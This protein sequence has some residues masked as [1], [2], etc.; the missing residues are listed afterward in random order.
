[1]D[2]AV[3]SDT[4]SST[5]GS[6]TDSPIAGTKRH[7]LEGIQELP[8]NVSDNG[9][10]ADAGASVSATLEASHSAFMPVGAKVSEES[11][12]PIRGQV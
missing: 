9:S 10:I 12:S 5:A 7:P 1:M 4:G 3:W 8:E 6:N 2:Q 11:S